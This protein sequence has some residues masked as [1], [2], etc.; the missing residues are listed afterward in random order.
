MAP[1]TAT[2][3]KVLDFNQ[4]ES[5]TRV[6]TELEGT[7]LALVSR[8]VDAKPI[9]DV[10][11]LEQVTEDRKQIGAAM[12]RVEEFFKP[13]KSM[14]WDLHKA[15]CARETGILSPLKTLD[16][17]KAEQMRQFKIAQD[18]IREAEER[19]QADEQRQQEQARAAHEAAAFETSGDHEMA[20][21][22]LEEAIAAPAPVVALQ[23]V[24]KGVATFVRNWRWKF[25]GG[26]RLDTKDLLKKS[27]PLIVARS[28]ALI[29]REFL[30][31]DVVKVNAYVEA[32]KGSAKIPG[33]DVFYTDDPRR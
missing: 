4:P 29:P 21:A 11:A 13:F 24:T 18:R 19:R 32:M 8:L 31:V 14:A 15:L 10:V 27:P 12:K 2:A 30:C 25:S 1:A 23:D 9:T 16:T 26:P 20:A 28:M 17:V 3:T 33:I 7:T 22:V 6:G 5:A